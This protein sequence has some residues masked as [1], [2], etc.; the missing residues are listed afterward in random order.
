[1]PIIWRELYSEAAQI[2]SICL[3]VEGQSL[4]ALTALDLALLMGSPSFETEINRMIESVASTLSRNEISGNKNDEEPSKKKQKTENPKLSY[5][6]RPKVNEKFQIPRIKAPTLADFCK[7]Y[8][9]GEKPVIITN[10]M[11]HW[12]AMG[13]RSW[14]NMDYLKKCAGYRTV[15]IEVGSTYLAPDWSQKLVSLSSFIDDYVSGN[16]DSI[17]YLAQTQ[18]FDQIPELRKDIGTP[19]YCGL[20]ENDNLIINAW[21]GPKG[22]VSPAHHDPYHNLLAQVV[23]EKYIRLYHPKYSDNLYPHNGRMLSNTSQ[24]DIEHPDKENFP[25]FSEAPY[26]ECILGEGEMLYIPP[27]WWQ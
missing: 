10:G 3:V 12:P 8:M 15:P 27:K 17:G 11:V 19:S 26:E 4:E 23:G 20:S 2:K 22:T 25:L 7:Y 5:L 21:F 18:L 24:V 9:K 14:K 13:E 1:V 16:N 6:D